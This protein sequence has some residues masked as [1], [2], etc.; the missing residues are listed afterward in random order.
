M[1]KTLNLV[2]FRTSIDLRLNINEK[3]LDVAENF[4][5]L[6]NLIKK[7]LFVVD[8]VHT[9]V[10]RPFRQSSPGAYRSPVHAMFYIS[11]AG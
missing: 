10:W 2:P 8:G 5:Q 6:N 9:R 1:L 3:F 4:E 7:G 11:V